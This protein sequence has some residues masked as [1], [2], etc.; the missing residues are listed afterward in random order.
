MNEPFTVPV[1]IFLVEDNPADVYLIQQVLEENGIHHELRVASDGSE[2]LSLLCPKG[3]LPL[4]DKPGLILLDLNLPKHDGMEILECIR[5]NHSLAAVPVIV[6]TSSDSPKDRSTAL[7]LG[8]TKYLRKP[9][10]LHEFIAIGG[11]IKA[12]LPE[13]SLS[14]QPNL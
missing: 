13:Y 4:P 5:Q 2:A 14:P 3:L 7:E 8:A 6:L 9:S 10:S 11:V 12:L 1:N